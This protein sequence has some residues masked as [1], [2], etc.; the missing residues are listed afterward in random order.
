[1]IRNVGRSHYRTDFFTLWS[2][3]SG[4][5]GSI[6]DLLIR[7]AHMHEDKLAAHY[8]LIYLQELRTILFKVGEYGTGAELFHVS[9]ALD[10]E[11]VLNFTHIAQ[12]QLGSNSIYN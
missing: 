3:V 6:W 10:K 7:E 12:I 11:N 5:K 2:W 4:S 1:M 8:A 9:I